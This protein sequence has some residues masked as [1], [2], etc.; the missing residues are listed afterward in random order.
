MPP[1]AKTTHHRMPWDQ[2][3]N[4]I[5]NHINCGKPN[6]LPQTYRSIAI[7]AIA[8]TICDAMNKKVIL[9]C[10]AAELQLAGS[11]KQATLLA[12]V[13]IGR[14]STPMVVVSSDDIPLIW[15]LPGVASKFMANEALHAVDELRGPLLAKFN[16]MV[17]AALKTEPEASAGPIRENSQMWGGVQIH[18]HLAGMP[19][20]GRYG[21]AMDLR[22]SAN[23]ASCS[24]EMRS[25]MKRMKTLMQTVDLITFVL[26]PDSYTAGRTTLHGLRKQPLTK[27]WAEAWSSA[28]TC[29]AV[30][31]NRAAP[32]HR[33]SK[34]DKRQYDALLN[35]GSA[36]TYLKVN[37]LHAEF[38]YGHGTAV[39]I[40]GSLFTHE[41]TT[42]VTGERVGLTF[43]MRKEVQGCFNNH[44][45]VPW[46]RPMSKRQGDQLQNVMWQDN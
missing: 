1:H 6:Q 4:I 26:H 3:L 8:Q 11:A 17:A 12:S 22:P 21:P 46:P 41:V 40:A 14:V 36:R 25:F 13:H 7:Q 9:P 34:G 28:F 18:I 27:S 23:L 31:A 38:E 2:M 35:F 5:E 45:Q 32:A 44:T 33:D 24:A 39:Y 37:N 30:M 10:S 29:L 16:S 20:V 15:Y 42:W 43:F 19:K